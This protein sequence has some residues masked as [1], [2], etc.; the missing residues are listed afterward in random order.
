MRRLR[1]GRNVPP[2]RGHR[3]YAFCRASP[4]LSG[5][6][7]RR[8][9]RPVPGRIAAAAQAAAGGGALGGG[10]LCYTSVTHFNLIHFSCHRDA[11]R[12]ERSLKQPK[13]EWEG[14]TLRNSQTKCNNLLPVH[15]ASVSD[16]AYMHCVE[17]WW[18][19]MVPVGR[20]DAP[21]CRL[22]ALDLKLLLL[23]FALEESFS[24]Y[25]K[26]QKARE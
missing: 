2:G 19:N 24:T 25:S 4:L 7:A 22:V 21:R 13:E 9:P 6:G 14:A 23:R 11:T 16:E 18:A 12:A 10:E 17:Q 3:R 20:V 26:E 5:G 1:R 15:S 8:W